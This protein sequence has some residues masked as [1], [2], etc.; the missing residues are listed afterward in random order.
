M[1]LLVFHRNSHL[2]PF[3]GYST[4]GMTLKSELGVV[5]GH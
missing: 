2:V 4:N 1:S 3:S 5:E